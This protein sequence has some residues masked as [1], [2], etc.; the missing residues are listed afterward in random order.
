MNCTESL[1][2]V[3]IVEHL[4]MNCTESHISVVI[5]KYLV[6]SRTESLVCDESYKYNSDVDE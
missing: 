3:V 6:M 1:I 5:V 4:V 2:S